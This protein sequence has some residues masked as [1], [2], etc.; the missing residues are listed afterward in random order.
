MRPKGIL[1][2]CLVLSEPKMRLLWLKTYKKTISSLTVLATVTAYV[3]YWQWGWDKETIPLRRT[4]AQSS[5]S[6]GGSCPPSPPGHVEPDTSSLWMDL[7]SLDSVILIMV[8][9][10]CLPFSYSRS[11]F[12]RHIS[13][14]V[15]KIAFRSLQI[16]KIWKF[17][18]KGYPRTP[19]KAPAFGT[20]DNAPTVTKNLSTALR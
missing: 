11:I 7:F 12:R 6:K 13:W 19:Y 5:T 2:S 10:N 3:S 1:G 8:T 17:S 18:G 20:R 9:C 14:Q 16:W 15:L 4:G